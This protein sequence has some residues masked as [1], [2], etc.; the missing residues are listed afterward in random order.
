MSTS[1]VDMM[2]EVLE[3][4]EWAYATTW[5]SVELDSDRLRSML[6]D[7]ALAR[8]REIYSFNAN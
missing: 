6:S 3:A 4:V 7:G 1:S 5:K 8:E 2:R